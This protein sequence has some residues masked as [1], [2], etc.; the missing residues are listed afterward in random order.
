MSNIEPTITV[1][2]TVKATVDNVWKLWTTPADIMQWNN[3]SE[4]WHNLLVEVDLK[5]E[6]RFLFRMQARDGSEGFDYCGKYD[7]VKTYELI[8][9]TTSD[10]RKAI[11]T[12]IP[13]GNETIVTETFEVETQTPIDIQR[14]F[15]QKVLNNFKKYTEDK[16]K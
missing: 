13:H 14:D 3:P 6:G 5:N 4:D 15:C 8:E 1:N 9:L 12:F 11:N 10:G 7:K 2:T 16:I